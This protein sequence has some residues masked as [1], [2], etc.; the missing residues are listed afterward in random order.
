[1]AAGYATTT[2]FLTYLAYVFATH[3]DVLKRARDEQRSLGIEGPLSLE[4]VKRMTYLEQVLCE[5]ERYYPPVSFGFRGVA[6]SFQFGQ[7]TVPKGWRLLYSI[8]A[9]HRDERYF[10]DPERFDPERFAGKTA[11]T[12]RGAFRLVGFGGGPR[13][14]P[15]MSLARTQAK[16]VASH[17]LRGYS[18]TLEPD[19]DMRVVFM[20]ARRPAGGLRVRFSKLAS[21]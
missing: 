17:L 7:Y 9:T 15:G 11:A 18:W 8:D 1:V 4:L 16:V 3:T 12:D 19:Q 20:P 6:E 5:V 21:E 14:C 13:V 2:S 10:P